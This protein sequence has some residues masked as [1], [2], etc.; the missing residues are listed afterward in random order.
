MKECCDLLGKIGNNLRHLWGGLNR[1]LGENRVAELMLV[2][3]KIYLCIH[4]D[5]RQGNLRCYKK[6]NV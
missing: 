3:V 2:F 4:L 1:E 6:Q 5:V